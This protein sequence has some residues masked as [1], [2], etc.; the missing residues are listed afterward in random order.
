MNKKPTLNYYNKIVHVLQ[1]L[2]KQFPQYNLGRHI[3]TALVEYGDI[4]SLS[5]KEVLFALEK[6]QA[7]L[8]FD[9]PHLDN[10]IDNII[11]DGMDLS[12]ILNEEDEEDGY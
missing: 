6:Y 2:H 4:W 1:E 12:N 8:E 10:D 11:K 5:D 9:I 3:S 7:E